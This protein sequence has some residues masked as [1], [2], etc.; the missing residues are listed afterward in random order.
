MKTLTKI[1]FKSRMLLAVILT[2]GL[3]GCGLSTEPERATY[4][5][6]S[7]TLKD[8]TT[9]TIIRGGTHSNMVGITCNY[10]N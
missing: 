3:V 1:K 4:S 5:E 8:G 6:E 9:C 10:D 7:Y 2:V